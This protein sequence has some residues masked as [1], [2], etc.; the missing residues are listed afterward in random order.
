MFILNSWAASD[1][2]Y[3]SGRLRSSR[4]LAAEEE[5]TRNGKKRTLVKKRKRNID[6]ELSDE[7]EDDPYTQI[8][9]EGKQLFANG[10]PLP[11]FLS[12]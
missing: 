11:I 8:N 2:T 9:I 5:Y 6:D 12:P 4:N 3:G 10:L 7:E 1:S